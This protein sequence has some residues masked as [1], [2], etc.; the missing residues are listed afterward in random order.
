MKKFRKDREGWE[1]IRMGLYKRC[2]DK[3]TD[4]PEAQKK[5]VYDYREGLYETP[6]K[7]DDEGYAYNDGTWIKFKTGCMYG[8]KYRGMMMCGSKKSLL[9]VLYAYMCFLRKV[10]VEDTLPMYYF[11]VRLILDRLDFKDGMFTGTNDNIKILEDYVKEV[12]K[13]DICDISCGCEDERKFCMNKDVSRSESSKFR[14]Y[15]KGEN[16]SK[17]IDELY[18][19]GMSNTENLKRFKDAG[20]DVSESTLQRWKR[21]NNKNLL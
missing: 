13:K 2:M 21:K 14:Q 3:D 4:I 8:K 17:R 10:G 15:K 7:F 18:D 12:F 20:L 16:T 9:K 19:P 1:T 6:K 5:L 11:T